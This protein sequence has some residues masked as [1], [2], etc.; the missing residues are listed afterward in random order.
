MKKKGR[1]DFF[2]Q[3]QIAEDRIA[4]YAKMETPKARSLLEFYRKA[5]AM[6]L[7]QA[8]EEQI[9]AMYMY[10]QDDF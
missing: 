1:A 2:R 10:D 8:S 5:K 7:L 6:L 4:K 3:V 9:T